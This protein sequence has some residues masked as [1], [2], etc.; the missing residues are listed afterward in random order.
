MRRIKEGTSAVLLQS[1]LDEK[2]LTDSMGCCCYLRNIRDLLSDGKT[3]Y[4][5][6]FGVPFN[7]PVILFGAMVEYRPTPVNDQSATASIR[8][9]SLVKR[10]P[11]ICVARGVNLERRHLGRT[12]WGIG[13]DKRIWNLCKKTRCKGSVNVYE[14]RKVHISN[15][16]WNSKTFWRRSPS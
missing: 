11:W 5:R 14:W 4:A 15:R 1:G 2:W 13:T 10:I 8:S 7:G 3:P 6:C 9:K 16:R 12:H